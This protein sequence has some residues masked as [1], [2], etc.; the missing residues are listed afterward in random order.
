MLVVDAGAPARRPRPKR[1]AEFDRPRPTA[2]RLTRTSG[3]AERRLD[4]DPADSGSNVAAQRGTLI[5][6]DPAA[7]RAFVFRDRGAV[8]SA[9]AD[10]W[11]H[12]DRSVALR[13]SWA[14]WDHA[15][16]VRPGWPT[17][18]E[19]AADLAAHVHLKSL[20]DQAS[21]ALARR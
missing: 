13:A 2:S 8:A 3:L 7:I 18:S 16:R 17:A 21:R 12:A 20:L 6:M 15:R 10:W 14:L 4:L 9:K 19:R 5:P 11:A 1:V